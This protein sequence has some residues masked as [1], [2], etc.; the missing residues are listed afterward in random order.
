MSSFFQRFNKATGS[1]EATEVKQF[2]TI[3]GGTVARVAIVKAELKQHERYGNSYN[4]GLKLQDGEFKGQTVFHNVKVFDANEKKADRAMEMFRRYYNIC[5]I[6]IQCSGDFPQ[7]Y[8]LSHF[9]GK[10]LVATISMWQSDEDP[11]KHGNWISSI[12]PFSEHHKPITGTKFPT[13]LSQQTSSGFTLPSAN[14]V[15]HS[16]FDDEAPF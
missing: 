6:E 4:F 10:E 5:G 2:E 1:K 13:T 14:I 9:L 16:T 15:Q 11:S 7:T 3:P 8:E 12:N